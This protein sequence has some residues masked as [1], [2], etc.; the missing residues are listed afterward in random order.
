MDRVEGELRLG[1]W[2]AMLHNR[3]LA[4][5]AERMAP[6]GLPGVAVP[7]LLRLHRGGDPSQDELSR[8]TGRDK[9]T[10]SR[11]VD[12]LEEEGFA[13]RIVDADDSRIKRVRLT[14]KGQALL[15][16][17]HECLREWNARLTEGFSPAEREIAR[18]LLERMAENCRRG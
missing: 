2:I 7:V 17:V 18:G 5:F 9:G 11:L 1:R 13:E 4:F 10:V 15:P 14:E 8:F 16:C 6:Y 3:A 12:R